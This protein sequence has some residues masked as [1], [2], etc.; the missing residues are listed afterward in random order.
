MALV[1]AALVA[2]FLYQLASTIDAPIVAGR[3]AVVI[4]SAIANVA[5]IAYHYIVPPHPKFLMIPWR[6]AVL[7]THITSGTVELVA[8]L[9]ACF[10]HSPRAATVM[11]LAALLFHVP[12]ALVQ[13]SIVFGS[14]AIMVPGY[15]F[16]IG[17]HA[18][19]AAMLLAHPTSSWWAVNTFLVFNVYVWCRIYFYVF[20]WARLFSSMKYTIAILAAGATI[21]PAVF[22]PM[23]ILL[24][25]GFVGAYILLYRLLFVSSPAEYLEFVRE[26]AR[27]ATVERDDAAFSGNPLEQERAARTVFDALDENK[28]GTLTRDDLTPVMISWGL[29]AAVIAS[30]I[31][32][33]FGNQNRIDFDVF[34]KH[35]W[36]IRGLRAR[37]SRQVK[38]R[39]IHSERD[40]AQFVFEQID[41][42]R[43]GVIGRSDLTLLL[44]EWG[45][46][47]EEADRYIER[48]DTNRNGQ[49]DFDEFFRHVRPV[50][51]FIFYDIYR[52][53]DAR[54]NT[55]MIGRSLTAMKEAGRVQDLRLRLKRE[56]LSH[57][58]FLA[59]ADE[60]MIS[61]LAESLV[62]EDF[63]TGATVFREGSVGDKFFLIASGIIRVSKN[64]E[65]IADLGTGGCVGEGALLSD[66]PRTATLTTVAPTTLYS[67]TRS[68][69]DYI[70][71][72]HPG[73]HDYLLSLHAQRTQ[74][75][76]S[77]TAA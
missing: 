66:E 73:M 75:T 59:G 26:R 41:L 30:V 27:D 71:G 25:A 50:W 70:T 21:A 39:E 38:L 4:L 2:P 14:K 46:P 37:A 54:E 49:I 11:A 8:G 51:R 42:D 28:Q 34:R 10:G 72:K 61:D 63:A 7:R 57:V 48:A 20:D 43:D 32:R 58:P 76:D 68:S 36:S 64:G 16:C 29:P 74:R 44:L 52:A 69:F 5:V 40:K 12:T 23:G 13:T 1:L 35:I 47:A 3:W 6:R 19:C 56:L 77:P 17:A 67:L 55:E 9:W 18:F 45:L 31:E 15:L 53:E 22:G 33:G 65:P 62:Q 60:N 24:L